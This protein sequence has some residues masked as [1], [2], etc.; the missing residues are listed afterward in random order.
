MSLA[1]DFVLVRFATKSYN[2]MRTADQGLEPW[3]KL[4]KIKF[5]RKGR[6]VYFELPEHLAKFTRITEELCQELRIARIEIKQCLHTLSYMRLKVVRDPL[7][8]QE[9][10]LIIE[11]DLPLN[12]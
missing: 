12:L 11:H 3:L 2:F 7:E 8:F 6:R 1:A 10:A 4:H 5:T 9:L